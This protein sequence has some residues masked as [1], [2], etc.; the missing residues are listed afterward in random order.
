M[1]GICQHPLSSGFLLPFQGSLAKPSVHEAPRVHSDGQST[2]AG[3]L[4]QQ[5]SKVP[6]Q[7]QEK[8]GKKDNHHTKEVWRKGEQ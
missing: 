2:T 8:A 1:D 5:Q 4:S 3:W 6:E 7:K